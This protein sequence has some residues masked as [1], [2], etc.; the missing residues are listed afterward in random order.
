MKKPPFGGFVRNNSIILISDILLAAKGACPLIV[1]LII[2]NFPDDTQTISSVEHLL[3]LVRKNI[4]I[5]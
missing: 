1:N 2:R 5:V 4:K 3:T